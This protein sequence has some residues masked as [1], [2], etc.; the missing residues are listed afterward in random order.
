MKT[1]FA[2]IFLSLNLT[3]MPAT[4]QEGSG[5]KLL[6]LD[7]KEKAVKKYHDPSIV[8]NK[9]PEIHPTLGR[10]DGDRNDPPNVVSLEEKRKDLDQ[11]QR[12]MDSVTDTKGEW[13]S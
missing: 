8:S 4:L 3:Q 2:L 9:P 13:P 10:G 7:V 5:L 11:R 12:D 1:V 6:S